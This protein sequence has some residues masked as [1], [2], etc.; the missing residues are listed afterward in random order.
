MCPCDR[1]SIPAGSRKIHDSKKIPETVPQ[2][3]CANVQEDSLRTH[4]G[5]SASSTIS[6]KPTDCFFRREKMYRLL[7]GLHAHLTR[8]E[9]FNVIIIGLDHAG[10]TTLLEKIKT[11]FN[12]SQPG[13]SPEKISQT[14]GQNIGRI[15]LSSTYLKFWDL[16]GSE[17]IRSIWEKYYNEADA[18]CW[19]VDSHDRHRNGRVINQN[20]SLQVESATI[21]DPKGKGKGKAGNDSS[22]GSTFGEGWL[23]LEKVLRHPSVAHSNIPILVIANKQDK[24]LGSGSAQGSSQPEPQDAASTGLN[25]KEH[26]LEPMSVEEVKKVFN[27]LVMESNRSEK[28]RSLGLSEANVIGVSALSGQ[29]IRDAVNWLFYRVAAKGQSRKTQ[30]QA[31]TKGPQ[32][33][34]PPGLSRNHSTAI[35]LAD[36]GKSPNSH[37][38]PISHTNSPA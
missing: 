32:G 13:L 35:R 31:K 30:Q 3:R 8:K 1:P 38:L 12:P 9:E 36:L 11:I 14:I 22:L 17:E 33:P 7:S 34:S 15:T 29:G 28:A 24:M 16:G 37:H 10:K 4:D 19:V 23:E 26:E 2:G 25:I 20:F 6:Y 21:G 27:N 5:A 18:I